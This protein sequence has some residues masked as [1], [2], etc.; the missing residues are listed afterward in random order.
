[1]DDVDAVQ[2]QVARNMF[3]SGNYVIE[4]VD[5]ILKM[6][7]APL[8]Y[9][10]IAAS[11]KVFGVHDWSA[12]IPVALSS[13]ACCWIAA[14]FG[15]WAFGKRAGFYAGMC[16]A[17]CVGLFLF[18]RILIPDAM[19]T[20]VIALALWAFLRAL[21]QNEKHPRRWAAILAASLGIAML[22]KSLVGVAFPVMIA[23]VYL[24]LRRQ[25]FSLQTW[26][27]CARS[28]AR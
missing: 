2:A 19:L 17:T 22:L 18:T 12:R 10:T 4:Q 13:I 21:D 15:I 24:L 26:N 27:A 11:Y 8:I 28:A 5:G 23:I 6:D 20:F 7:K 14:A 16:M 3:T 25:L 1:M 9:W